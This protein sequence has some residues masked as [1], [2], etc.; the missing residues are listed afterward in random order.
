VDKFNAAIVSS[1]SSV[2]MNALI[3]AGMTS[4]ARDSGAT[5]MQVARWARI[6][7]LARQL[8]LN[9][10]TLIFGKFHAP[11]LSYYPAPSEQ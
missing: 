8:R 9:L 2:I 5:H 6:D 4:T 10:M 1:L 11:M 7:N 3:V